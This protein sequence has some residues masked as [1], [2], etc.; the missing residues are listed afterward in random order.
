M[1]LALVHNCILGYVGNISQTRVVNKITDNHG[2]LIPSLVVHRGTVLIGTSISNFI[3][4]IKDGRC[5]RTHG[6]IAATGVDPTLISPKDC[7]V[8]L[9]AVFAHGPCLAAVRNL[10][11]GGGGDGHGDHVTLI[12]SFII[13]SSRNPFVGA[14]SNATIFIERGTL[15]WPHAAIAVPCDGPCILPRR[16]MGILLV[17]WLVTSLSAEIRIRITLALEHKLTHG[18]TITLLVLVICGTLRPNIGAAAKVREDIERGG[19]SGRNGTV[20]VTQGT[21]P[22]LTPILANVGLVPVRA[23]PST[24]SSSLALIDE[25]VHGNLVIG[26]V[27][28]RLGEGLWTPSQILQDIE[29]GGGGGRETSRTGTFLSPSLTPVERGA[30]F[31]ARV[32]APVASLAGVDQGVGSAVDGDLIA[33]LVLSSGRVGIGAAFLVP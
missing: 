13:G 11:L 22:C 14:C 15:S 19:Y 31:V 23:T 4:S 9:A 28:G 20:A 27:L 29:R 33:G 25:A 16:G 7:G 1:G 6:S 10:A 3:Q 24:L 18:N 17:H 5:S 26:L 12:I 2:N 30:G 8:V 32:A 21:I